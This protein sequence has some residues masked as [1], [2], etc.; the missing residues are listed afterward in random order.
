LFYFIKLCDEFAAELSLIH[1]H[2]TPLL[3]C[4]YAMTAAN[5]HL[6]ER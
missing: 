4:C 2:G 1:Y 6:Y 5:A 3:K